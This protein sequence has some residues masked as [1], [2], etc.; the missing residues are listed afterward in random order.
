M[1]LPEFRS[2]LVMRKDAKQRYY[3]LIALA[4]FL[5]FEGMTA[6]QALNPFAFFPLLEAIVTSLLAVWHGY[7]V[8]IRMPQNV[9]AFLP[10]VLC[11]CGARILFK[12]PAYIMGLFDGFSLSGL[13]LF[14]GEICFWA[15]FAPCTVRAVCGKYKLIVPMIFLFFGF[16]YTF[17]KY[18]LH[19]FSSIGAQI[20]LILLLWFP[21]DSIAFTTYLERK[22]EASKK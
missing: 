21:V 7:L 18:D 5:F 22:K 13:L 9:T 16:F 6:V 3:T 8:F 1:K 10:S 4:V 15:A 17:I 14:L 2:P 19:A 20:C 11:L 12:I